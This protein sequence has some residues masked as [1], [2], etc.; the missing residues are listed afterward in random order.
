MLPF[1]VHPDTSFSVVT[2]QGG[3][4]YGILRYVD[5][6]PCPF[7]HRRQRGRYHHPNR[8][9]QKEVR[10]K[11]PTAIGGFLAFWCSQHRKRLS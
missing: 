11:P 5:A 7:G 8:K 6:D 2:L 9:R 3:R 10:G 4:Y 1:R